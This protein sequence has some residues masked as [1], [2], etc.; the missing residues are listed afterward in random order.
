MIESWER[1]EPI[2][3]LARCHDVEKVV[4]S[5]QNFSLEIIELETDQN[6]KI[7]LDFGKTV[8]AYRNVYETFRVMLFTKL[9]NK[10]GT[11]FYANWTFF[12]VQD[13]EYIKWIE[14]RSNTSC[15]SIKLS[16]FS[17]LFNDSVVDVI[18]SQEPKIILL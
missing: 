14:Q 4:E 6:N 2:P 18:A 1:W 16:H 8:Q 17:F 10:Y 5:F 15:S 12:K 7:L 3:N 13:S 9:R 11:D